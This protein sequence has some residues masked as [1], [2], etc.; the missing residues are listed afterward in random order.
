MCHFIIYWLDNMSNPVRQ[1]ICTH[2]PKAQNPALTELS[3]DNL[4]ICKA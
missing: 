4:F 3:R 2:A 1:I